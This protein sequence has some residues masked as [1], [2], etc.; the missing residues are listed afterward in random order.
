MSQN[1]ELK[2]KYLA[3]WKQHQI[4]ERKYDIGLSLRYGPN[5]RRCEFR[6][7]FMDPKV[8]QKALKERM[9]IICVKQLSNYKREYTLLTN[10]GT[11]YYVIIGQLNYCSCYRFVG[12][13][14]F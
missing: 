11:I 4:M 1:R 2:K 3:H 9:F 12:V 7:S 14:S 13:G 5:Q 8:L 10:K 6:E